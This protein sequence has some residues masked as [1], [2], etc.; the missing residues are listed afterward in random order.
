M[1]SRIAKQMQGAFFWYKGGYFLMG[2][3]L[4][5]EYTSD[6]QANA[7]DISW[8]DAAGAAALQEEEMAPWTQVGEPRQQSPPP[9]QALGTA[10]L[11][12]TLNTGE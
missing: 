1:A 9:K 8:G 7:I 11:C 5:T 3:T 2:H 12:R 10:S 6:R 4:W